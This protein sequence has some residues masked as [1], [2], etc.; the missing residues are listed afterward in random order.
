MRKIWVFLIG[1]S[2]MLLPSITFSAK[3]ASN[4]KLGFSLPQTIAECSVGDKWFYHPTVA[5]DPSG[6]RH[7]VYLEYEWTETLGD[8]YSII[9]QGPFES[10]IIIQDST[11]ELGDPNIA[12]DSK[13]GLHLVY[14]K[15][16]IEPHF[17]Y[18][19]YMLV[20]KLLI[21][22]PGINDHGEKMTDGAEYLVKGATLTI[23]EVMKPSIRDVRRQ[24]QNLLNAAL[25]MG[26]DVVVNIDMN[27]ENYNILDYL[28]PRNRWD[29]S[30]KW[31]GDM[32]NMVSS[33]F[34][35][36]CALGVIMVYAHSA[37][38][39][40]LRRS[41]EQSRNKKMFDDIN[42]F[43]GRT[44]VGGLRDSLSQAGYQWWQV[45]IFTSQN[46]LPAAPS[47][48]SLKGGSISNYE[49]AKA[50]AGKTWVHLH[51][52]TGDHNALRDRI[53]EEFE[54]EVNQGDVGSH[55]DNCITTPAKM[56]L[57]NWLWGASIC[58]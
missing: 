28:I 12:V 3:P 33:I 10:Q 14:V 46:D 54:F 27:L 43:N 18:I 42:I 17:S 39:D 58:E 37:G 45:K 56:I 19:Y 25:K 48:F 8:V 20:P 35:E 23:Q 34:K 1:L 47:W 6:N 31:A 36:S 32:A 50:E 57:W 16:S 52:K 51:A 9:Y 49:A 11:T 2:I 40:A 44:T 13:G 38:G 21:L 41:M 29:L 26:S 22:L 15:R 5:V 55:V 30:T 53:G 24:M 7:V 4:L